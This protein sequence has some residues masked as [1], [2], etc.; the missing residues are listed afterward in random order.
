MVLN[1]FMVYS[2]TFWIRHL[3]S[4]YIIHPGIK[5]MWPRLNVGSN[6]LSQM[7]ELF[8]LS[9]FYC[10]LGK[11][12][13]ERT[14]VLFDFITCKSLWYP[15]F[16]SPLSVSECTFSLSFIS[17]L[18]FSW[19]LWFLWLIDNETLCRPIWSVIALMIKEVVS[20]QS[21]DHYLLNGH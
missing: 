15:M 10:L 2:K 1:T 12:V 14:N 4:V 3:Q 21:C 5:Y 13:I 18:F 9:S 16:T 19:K 11:I 8:L 6:I 7:K 17:W 20:T